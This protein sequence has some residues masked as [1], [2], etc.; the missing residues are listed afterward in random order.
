LPLASVIEGSISGAYCFVCAV[1]LFRLASRPSSKLA[2]R[3]GCLPMH[4]ISAPTTSLPGRLGHL[5]HPFPSLFAD[6][7]V[8][9]TVRARILEVLL[10]HHVS[11]AWIRSTTR[12][13][14][15]SSWVH[16]CTPACPLAFALMLGPAHLSKRP[17]VPRPP[18]L[19]TC[20]YVCM[21]M[22]ASAHP[23]GVPVR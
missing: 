13:C 7:L 22:H 23:H 15:Q 4:P 5:V 18:A 17:P 2:S 6:R 10:D 14:R 21:F 8:L 19:P 1:Q 3:C 11:S 20:L 12:S 9:T 16:C